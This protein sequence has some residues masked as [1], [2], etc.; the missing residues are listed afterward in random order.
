MC[1]SMEREHCWIKCDC[2]DC[3]CSTLSNGP[4]VS[5]L[6]QP[7]GAGLCVFF[8]YI[9]IHDLLM[10]FMCVFYE[11]VGCLVGLWVSSPRPKYS[12]HSQV[13]QSIMLMWQKKKKKSTESCIFSPADSE[14]EEPGNSRCQQTAHCDGL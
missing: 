3:T 7:T 5:L 6:I 9:Y 8:F 4:L 11:R 10:C 14:P 2:L 13:N 1:F 12:N